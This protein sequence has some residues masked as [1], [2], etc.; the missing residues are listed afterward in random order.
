MTAI[1]PDGVD[2]ADTFGFGKRRCRRQ[3]DRRDSAWRSQLRCTRRVRLHDRSQPISNGLHLAQLPMR[4][5]AN[6]ERVAVGFAGP[7][8]QRVIDRRHEDLAVADL[9]CARAFGD[10][11]DRPVREVG[12]DRDFDS[13]LGQEIH[14]IFG[15][16]INFGMALLAAVTLDLGDR[17]AVDPDR[18]QR[19]AHLVKFEGFDNGNNELHD[20]AFIS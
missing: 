9:A 3:S 10:D 1:T 5:K 2:G 6:S 11:V 20:R 8:P 16:A 18:R 7:Y 12:G 13:E 17:H 19:L 15:T 4:A 14:D